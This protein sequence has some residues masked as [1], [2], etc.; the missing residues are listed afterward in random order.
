MGVQAAEIVAALA[1][2]GRSTI[3]FTGSR[4]LTEL[5]ARWAAQMAPR[6]A[7]SPYRAG[8]LP[9]ERREIERQLRAG[10]LDAVVSTNAL[11]LGI[12]IGGL[13][14][15]VM[16]GYPGTI[17][18]TW[19]QI[20]RAGRAHRP[21]L[22]VLVT[23][24]D[25]LDSYLARRPETLF[26]APV[27]R[28]VVA[29]DNP[30]VLAGQ[31]LCAAAELP[32]REDESAGFGGALPGVLEALR[33]EGLVAP[34]P[35]GLAYVGRSRP[36]SEVRLDG[37]PE[38]AVEL[39]VG[40]AVIEI[41]ERWRAMR[42]AF[43]GAVFLHRGESFRVAQ[44]DLEAGV[45]VAE[46]YDGEEHTRAVVVRAYGVGEP[47]ESRAIGPWR[48]G[49]GDALVRSQV[50]A[51][52]QFRH[53]ELLAVHPLEL[54]EVVLDTRGLSLVPERELG[55]ILG[56]GVDPLASLHA[57]EHA[58]IHAMP[59]LAMCDRQDAGGASM[60]L[61]A[62]SARPLVLV[63]DGYDGGSGIVDAAY[64]HVDALV[65]IAHDMLAT[66]DC[67]LGC[68]RCVFDR[69]CGSGNADLDRPGALQVLASLRPS[70][71]AEAGTATA[72]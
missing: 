44:L 13:D 55:E 5:V 61:E 68:P 34:V 10:E 4:V 30:S 21:A 54:P 56:G 63:Y 2:S 31:V 48:V 18:S 67:E 51:Y 71:R 16:A 11:E 1:N 12:D 59:L 3:C 70:E 24:E 53:D 37:R 60:L 49:I 15:V 45:A 17:A 43:T 14:A 42:Q 39:R 46:P 32:V 25:P 19:Q 20:G 36:A 29:L 9:A 57:A 41:L 23:G 66:C 22:A 28:A 52:R 69:D 50:V 38:G 35:A 7:I 47:E 26:G 65:D 27:E 58:L 62:K 64:D 6:A 33:G 8:Y 40:G 72:R